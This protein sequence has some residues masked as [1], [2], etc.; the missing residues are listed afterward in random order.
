MQP[1][2]DYATWARTTGRGQSASTYNPTTASE[3]RRFYEQYVSQWNQQYTRASAAALRENPA[4]FDTPAEGAQ[5]MSEANWVEGLLRQEANRS[6]FAGLGQPGDPS[7]QALINPELEYNAAAANRATNIARAQAGASGLGR[8][9]GLNTAERLI[10]EDLNR[11][12]I[13]AM[14]GIRSGLLAEGRGGVARANENVG[15]AFWQRSYELPESGG[16]AAWNPGYTNYDW[17]YGTGATGARPGTITSAPVQ[18]PRTGGQPVTPGDVGVRSV[19]AR[20]T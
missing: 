9:G 20:R 14:R 17:A 19:T 4:A 12:N 5:R 15:N 1:L 2:M 3:N 16:G 6:M 11:Q 10:Q 18:R 13:S 8:G 7:T